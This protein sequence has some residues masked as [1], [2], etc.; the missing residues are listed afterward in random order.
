METPTARAEEVARKVGILLRGCS[1]EEL[2]AALE[3]LEELLA[4]CLRDGHFSS[5]CFWTAAFTLGESYEMDVE[6]HRL[7]LE[8]RRTTAMH[9]PLELV[10]ASLSTRDLRIRTTVVLSCV[11]RSFQMHFG[12]EQLW[13]R[14]CAREWPSSVPFA[15]NFRRFSYPLR[16]W[17]AF[18]K[19]RLL[20]ETP[21]A[22][23]AASA[24]PQIGRAF[25]PP[26]SDAKIA[27]VSWLL[28]VSLR[29]GS[30]PVFSCLLLSLLG[31]HDAAWDWRDEE[32]A[33]LTPLVMD[34]VDELE[35][36]ELTR[37]E[38]DA[39]PSLT[40]SVAALLGGG[41][42]S[43]ERPASLDFEALL[44]AEQ[45]ASLYASLLILRP[46]NGARLVEMEG[47]WV[48]DDPSDDADE[49]ATMS[50]EEGEE[51]EAAP[52]PPARRCRVLR[53]SS[54]DGSLPMFLHLTVSLSGA[55][56]PER[57][58]AGEEDEE[59][60]EEEGDAEEDEEMPEAGAGLLE[61]AVDPRREEAR[62]TLR[63]A[64]SRKRAELA[65]LEYLLEHD[66]SESDLDE[67]ERGAVDALLG[68]VD[69][70]SPPP[71]PAR[72]EVCESDTSSEEMEFDDPGEG[73]LARVER[74]RLAAFTAGGVVGAQER[75]LRQLRETFCDEHALSY[76]DWIDDDADPTEEQEAALWERA[77]EMWYEALMGGSWTEI[78]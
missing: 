60:E 31:D 59:E 34:D 28:D 75:L 64:I 23:P 18:G 52:H 7:A 27:K 42:N 22:S 72:S 3:R 19:C 26:L 66:G 57:E 54:A 43:V 30:P 2:E 76:D 77:R 15:A 14:L 11:S 63:Q 58:E 10:L 39:P 40:P 13:G 73:A 41:C 21:G 24:A 1:D 32:A 25:F 47:C 56:P 74:V 38:S 45:S 50:D 9:L 61:P 48:S 46:G 12:G 55:V 35:A 71:S 36:F 49:L 78:A 16:S 53:M 5:P 8:T 6:A 51:G 17:R 62:R 69:L 70:P 37:L 29:K 4:R 68:D 33:D 67:E 20:L 65:A 44:D